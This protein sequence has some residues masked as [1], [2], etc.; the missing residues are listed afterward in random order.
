RGDDLVLDDRSEGVTLL[1]RA[2][3]LHRNPFDSGE[4][5][6][7][8]AEGGE[9][10]V[11]VPAE[12]AFG[13]GT[14]AERRLGAPGADQTGVR[15]LEAAK[16]VRRVTQ[17]RSKGALHQRVLRLAPERGEGEIDP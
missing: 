6:D 14:N 5:V 13:E 1:V 4:V 17:R 3:P 9:G 15:E 7:P 11:E 12:G 10:H 8:V 16:G 2:A